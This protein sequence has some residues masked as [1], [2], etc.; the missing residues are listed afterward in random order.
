MPIGVIQMTQVS[1]TAV[2]KDAVLADS[3]EMLDPEEIGDVYDHVLSR[4][5]VNTATS[6][7]G[8]V[9]LSTAPNLAPKHKVNDESDA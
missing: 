6:E 9:S 8:V 1:R 4:M 3:S 5:K 7:Q 2:Q